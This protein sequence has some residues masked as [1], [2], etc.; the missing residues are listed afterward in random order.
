MQIITRAEWG[1]PGWK[2]GP[3]GQRPLSEIVGLT[4]HN[5]GG[6]PVGYQTGPSV[7]RATNAFHQNT[8]GWSAIGYHYQIDQAGNI[9]EGRGLPYVG[10]H[11]P[12]FNRNRIGVQFHIGGKEAPSDKALAAF[13]ELRAWI[14]QQVGKGR[15]SVN[16]HRDGFNTDCPGEALYARVKAN[17][18]PRSAPAQPAQEK[19]AMD[20]TGRIGDKWRELGGTRSALGQPTGGEVRTEKG[21]W[22]PFAG[23]FMLY[24]DEL[25]D[26]FE[27]RGAIRERYADYGYENGPLGYPT[28]DELPAKDGGRFQTFQ[29]GAIYWHPD[30]GAHALYGRIRDKWA[31]LGWE[32]G[33]LGYPTGDEFAGPN[34]G[35]IQIF[36]GGPVYWT[37][38]GDAHPVW[39][40]ML[41]QYA[42]DGYEN[43]DW[44][45]PVGDEVAT[46]QGWA[47][48]FQ[49]DT[50]TVGSRPPVT[51]KIATA[52]YRKPAR[53]GYTVF[54]GFPCCTCLAEWLPRYERELL[55]AGIIKQSIDIYQLRG[56][57]PA[58]GG[59]H[60][61]GGA[62]DI[63]QR[64]PEAIRI[65][66]RMGSAAWAREDMRPPHQHGVLKGCDTND[67]AWYQIVALNAGYNGLGS[68]GRGGRD[69]GPRTG[70]TFP[71][72]NWDDGI[73]R[74][75]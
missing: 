1:F 26:A 5:D 21:A 70:I 60:T 33:R 12:A 65:A 58:S 59:T 24:S 40:L 2:G 6:V 35:R 57:A 29:R 32:H 42:R 16:G 75:G 41:E 30:A 67:P 34:G 46:A 63:V 28:S 74:L 43:G 73:R 52:D 50:M 56:G 17:N 15:L 27:N 37:L 51:A 49:R 61:Q 4:V 64:S 10:A 47:Q 9:F 19:P 72:I 20:V 38:S 44:G 31:E 18:W 45:Y 55:N 66:R 3:P 11:A 23:G 69:A 14:E 13:A 71:I 53:H 8:Q 62:Y 54:R 7:P 68:G 25:G 48:R 39:G 22:R 36:Q